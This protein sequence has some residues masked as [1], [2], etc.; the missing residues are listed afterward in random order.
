MPLQTTLKLLPTARD[1][2]VQ[3][4]V[5]NPSKRY[6]LFDQMSCSWDTAWRSD[7]E[8]ILLAPHEC[9]KNTPH[10]IVLPPGESF[11][12]ETWPL[13]IRGIKPGKVTFRLGL[14]RSRTAYTSEEIEEVYR[15]ARRHNYFSP[16]NN[17]YTRQKEIFWSNTVT[18][19]L[20]KE[21]IAGHRT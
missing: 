1:L 14:M 12:E 19:S 9:A 13:W 20:R 8:G 4:V 18:V 15:S 7:R 10:T 11:R 2:R 21:W 3:L 5:H 17:R 6:E 16:F